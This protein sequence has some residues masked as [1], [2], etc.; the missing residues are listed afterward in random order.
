[1]P[2]VVIPYPI[3]QTPPQSTDNTTGANTF[4][5]PFPDNPAGLLYT[6]NAIWLNGAAPLPAY[7]S[8]G[9]TTVAAVAAYANTN[10]SDYGTWT[11]PST[12]ILQLVS[13]T[14]DVQQVL[15]AG[16]N[17]ALTPTNFCF[18]LTAYST[19]ASVNGVKFGSGPIMP[20]PAFLLTNNPITLM[21]VL[22][23]V[24]S[25]QTVFDPTSVANK[26]GILTVQAQPKLYND[27]VLVETATAAV[28]S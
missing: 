19:P 16:M 11:N 28:C 25:S 9:K 1:M 26:L 8:A 6:M 22:A 7:V 5:F 21:N 18:N 4:I 10:W 27:A 13:E 24:M 15:T 20:V 23:K 2:T 14:D 3:L 12:N 17:V